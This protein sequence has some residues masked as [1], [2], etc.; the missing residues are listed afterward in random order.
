LTETKVAE[1]KDATS[2]GIAARLAYAQLWRQATAMLMTGPKATPPRSS[3]VRRMIRLLVA[4]GP[5]T[6][7]ARIERN[8]KWVHPTKS[9]A[10][11]S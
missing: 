11:R 5:H 3:T 8:G 10:A 7:G 9:R 2:K 6:Q 4:K 1:K